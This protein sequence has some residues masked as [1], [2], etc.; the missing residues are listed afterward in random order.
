MVIRSCK[1]PMDVK[2]NLYVSLDI[3]PEIGMNGSKPQSN[4]AENELL[5]HQLS[6]KQ[7]KMVRN[8]QKL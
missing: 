7:S 3:I 2:P 5:H 6:S 1:V 8:G 4:R